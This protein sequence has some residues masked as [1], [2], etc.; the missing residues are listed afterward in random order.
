[1]KAVFFDLDGVLIDSETVQ[2]RILKENIERF[3]L[4]IP[5]E[6]FIPLIGSHKSLDLWEKIIAKHQLKQSKEELR[7]LL[8]GA[9]DHHFHEINKKEMLFPEVPEVLKHLRQKGVLLACASSSNRR[10]IMQALKECEIASCFDLI[11]TSDDFKR[12]KPAPDIYEH[13]LKQLQVKPE[14]SLV[15]EDSPIGIQAAK[16]AKIKVF[17]RRNPEIALDQSQADAWIDS[18]EALL[19]LI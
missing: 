9:G 17:A 12:S 5:A 1:M 11:T 8:F 14:E 18:L 6:A 2:H 4:D 7:E 3:Q 16:A 10:Y 13:C 19:Q 15:V